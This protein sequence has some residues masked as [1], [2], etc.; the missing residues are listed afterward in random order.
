MR[1]SF[2]TVSSQLGNTKGHKVPRLR[3]T[4]T[5]WFSLYIVKAFI[6]LILLFTAV[7]V[8]DIR[9]PLFDNGGE[10]E[11]MAEEILGRPMFVLWLH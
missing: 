1:A 6:A 9:A 2:Y 7:G 10:M 8:P 5:Y 3:A 11:D 4:C